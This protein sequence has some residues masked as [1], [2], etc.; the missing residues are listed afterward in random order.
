MNRLVGKGHDDQRAPLTPPEPAPRQVL[1]RADIEEDPTPD[2]SSGRPPGAAGSILL[3]ISDNGY[4]GEVLIAAVAG[5]QE[6]TA[7]AVANEIVSGEHAR[8]ASAPDL[9]A[10]V[11]I[12]RMPLYTSAPA[13]ISDSTAFEAMQRA[14]IEARMR[15]DLLE[16]GASRSERTGISRAGRR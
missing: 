13:W 5:D 3:V 2:P 6:D 8:Y 12:R 11:R 7:V 10:P 1:T 15:D 9:V 4:D 14:A 16:R